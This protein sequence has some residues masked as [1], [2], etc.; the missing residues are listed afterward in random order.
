[1]SKLNLPNGLELERDGRSDRAAG[2]SSSCTSNRLR[3]LRLDTEPCC[4]LSWDEKR[5]RAYL[6][7]VLVQPGSTP[8]SSK[9][10]IPAELDNRD[11]LRADDMGDVT[12]AD[13]FRL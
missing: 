10:N 12:D 2:T 8:S 13:D 4:E 6:E 7:S 1:M 3:L 9:S 5:S 11:V